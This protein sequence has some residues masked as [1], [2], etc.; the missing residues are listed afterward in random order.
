MTA[1]SLFWVAPIGSMIALLFAYIFYRQIMKMSEGEPTMIKIAGHVRKGAMAYLKQ[2]YKVVFIFFICAGVGLGILAWQGM[3]SKW[4]PFAFF[5]GGFFSGLAGFIGMKTATNGSARTAFAAKQSLNMGLNVAFRA[6]AV[7]GLTVVGLG[8][9]DI[10]LWFI[11]L[12]KMM[13]YDLHIVTTT[14]LC[15]G[16]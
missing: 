14:M 11:V 13:G 8:L 1:E 6:G 9:L 16:M 4:V 5:T 2:Q 3:Q 7:M 15:F 10:S 12:R